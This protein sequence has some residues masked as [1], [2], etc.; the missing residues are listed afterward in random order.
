MEWI[1]HIAFKVFNK[2]E[3]EKA[4]VFPGQAHHQKPWRGKRKE[5]PLGDMIRVP[6]AERKL[7]EKLVLK[8]EDS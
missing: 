4:A 8:E 7:L 5:K 1:S 2:R 6:P 3:N